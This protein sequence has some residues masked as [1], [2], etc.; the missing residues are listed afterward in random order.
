MLFKNKK[1]KRS[2]STSDLEA[3]LKST[4]DTEQNDT[5]IVS[6]KRRARLKQQERYGRARLVF[7][8]LAVLSII[9]LSFITNSHP[10][11]NLVVVIPTEPYN[12]GEIGNKLIILI[13]N[14]ELLL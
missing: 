14:I 12:A 11:Q 3:L 4:S 1:P 13:I 9:Y 10:Y 2:F 5:H 8:V 7:L 6:L